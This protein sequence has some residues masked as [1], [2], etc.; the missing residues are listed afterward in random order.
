MGSDR[1]GCP[2]LAIGFE[3]LWAFLDKTFGPGYATA[4]KDARIRGGSPTKGFLSG[5]NVGL[6]AVIGLARTA[7]ST[8]AEFAGSSLYHGLGVGGMERVADYP[9]SVW[10]LMIGGFAVLSAGASGADRPAP[11]SS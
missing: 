4:S 2:R 11:L 8:A 10:L 1:A 6:L 7:L 9:G 3:F 5:A